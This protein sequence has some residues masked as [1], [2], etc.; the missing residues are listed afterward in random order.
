MP[1]GIQLM[2]GPAFVRVFGSRLPRTMAL[3]TLMERRHVRERHYYIPYVG[4]A[5]G[6]QGH[7]LGTALLTPTLDRCDREGLPSYL[8]AT[9]EKNAALYERLGFIATDELRLRGSPPLWPMTRPPRSGLSHRH[10]S[11]GL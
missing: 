11:R 3:L 2:H 8:E 6:S 7:G 9:S 10:V 1:L 5:P 4:V